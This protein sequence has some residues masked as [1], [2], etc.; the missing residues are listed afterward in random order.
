MQICRRAAWGI[1]HAWCCAGLWLFY[2]QLNV[3]W[4]YQ[5]NEMPKYPMWAP[6]D[7]SALTLLHDLKSDEEYIAWFHTLLG[8]NLTQRAQ[9][10]PGP[11]QIS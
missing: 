7:T 8:S 2:S 3:T 9:H 1:H 11:L 10:I 4:V 6:N 5:C